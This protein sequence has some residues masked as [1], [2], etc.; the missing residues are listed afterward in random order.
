MGKRESDPLWDVLRNKLIRDG[1]VQRTDLYNIL[2]ADLRAHWRVKGGGSSQEVSNTVAHKLEELLR[3]CVPDAR[4]RLSAR[5]AYN[6]VSI[7]GL[8]ANE[9]TKLSERFGEAFEDPTM[10]RK[11]YSE[12]E[13]IRRLQVDDGIVDRLIDALRNEMP[14]ASVTTVASIPAGTGYR[15]RSPSHRRLIIGSG[16]ALALVAG[17]ITLPLTLGSPAANPDVAAPVDIESVT[18][19]PLHTGFSS[20]FPGC[21]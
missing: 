6:I 10:K 18:Y 19:Q 5:V 2:G 15:R 9:R 21:G 17:A 16:V 13:A 12:R 3:R 11:L 7:P 20:A 14:L 1:G 8:E 4:E